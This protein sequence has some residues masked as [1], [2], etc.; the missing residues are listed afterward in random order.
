MVC[1]FT[2]RS[3]DSDGTIATWHWEFSDDDGTTISG[4]SDD[5]NTTF[6]FT[7][8]GSNKAV[9][10]TVT[11]NLGATDSDFEGGLVI[12]PGTSFLRLAK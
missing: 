11:D 7:D 9:T 3:T 1:T 10:L 12:T 4:T 5:Q 6:T 8:N 2:D